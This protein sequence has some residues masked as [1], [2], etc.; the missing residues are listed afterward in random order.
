MFI[1]TLYLQN[2]RSYVEAY[3]EFCPHVNLICGPNAK[4]KT[5]LLEAIH[6]LMIGRSFRTAQYLDLIR[7]TQP[8]FY[9]ESSFVKHGIDQTLRIVGNTKERQIIH[10]ST[11]FSSLSN[12]LGLMQGVLQTPDDVNIIKGAPQLRRQFLD[13]QIAQADPLYVHHLTRYARAMRQ[14]NQL[15]RTKNMSTIEAWEFEMS[16]SGAYIVSK[17]QQTIKNLQ[18]YSQNYY[19]VL[20]N[21]QTP[22]VLNYRTNSAHLSDLEEIKLF[23]QMQYRKHRERE[24]ILG[25]TLTGPHKDDF[26]ILIEGRDV[27]LFASEGQQRSCATVLHF[28]EWESLRKA[29]AEKP[30]FMIDDV[31]ISLDK[32]RRERLTNQLAGLGQVFL[33]TTD[34]TFL[35]SYSGAKAIFNLENFFS[36]GI[37]SGF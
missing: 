25:Y 13:I 32:N 34:S 30:L 26:N 28:A 21:E 19:T 18:E 24:R 5:S 20:T 2:F 7:Q 36:D 15:L 4:G 37:S 14:R 35:E 8:G 6:L 1:K 16:Q 3:F 10:N 33:T 17:R 31:G 29:G 27:R 11:S 23:F 22:L 9:V 12:L